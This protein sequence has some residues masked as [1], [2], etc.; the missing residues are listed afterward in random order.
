MRTNYVGE[1]SYNGYQFPA[2]LSAKVRS[3]P[4]MDNEERIVKYIRYVLD[5]TVVI[6]AADDPQGTTDSYVEGASVND[7]NPIIRNMNDIRQRLLEPGKAL[8]FNLQGFGDFEVNTTTIPELPAALIVRDINFGP[9]PRVLSWEPIGS[10]KAVRIVWQCETSIPECLE[11]SPYYSNSLANFE[12]EVEWSVDESG[13]TERRLIGEIEIPN[14]WGKFGSGD[15]LY[16]HAD[17]YREELHKIPALDGFAR[18]YPLIR[19]SK[20]RRILS[21]AILDKEIPSNNPLHPGMLSMDINHN[22]K[23]QLSPS[24]FTKWVCT[25]AGTVVVA[26]GYSKELAW[27][28]IISVVNKRI[29][30]AKERN[31]TVWKKNKYRLMP[32]YGKLEKVGTKISDPTFFVL[33]VSITEQI[34]G[35]SISFS[36]TYQLISTPKNLLGPRGNSQLFRPLNLTYW[37]DWNVSLFDKVQNSRGWAQLKH[38]SGD[39]TRVSL[40]NS[41]NIDGSEIDKPVDDDTDT[42]LLTTTCPK[43]P[44]DSWI[45]F[46]SSIEISYEGD[47]ILHR[48]LQ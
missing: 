43:N 29:S 35:R 42:A 38:Q 23:S 44:K 24:G 32:N 48:K 13:M 30:L 22:V 4:V 9:K 25:L 8:I 15:S 10:S 45:D 19:L 1:V 41:N 7:T 17:N 33:G 20:N 16:D 37:K 36:I 21:F 26:P 2:P 34:F 14:R 11:G 46:H 40:C 5:I 39:D 3:E 27:N 31:I 47:V 18:S 12:Y 28:A 6:V